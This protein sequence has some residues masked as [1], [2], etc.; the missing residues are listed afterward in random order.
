MYASSNA[1]TDSTAIYKKIKE[2]SSKRKLTTWLY[3]A[4]FVDPKPQ[5]YPVQP[6]ST[7]EKNVNP[8][9]K[10]EGRIIKKINVTVYDPFGHSVN[11]TIVRK[12]NTFEKGANRAHI[13]T[14]H[15]VI[16]NKLLFKENDELEAIEL[17]ESERLLRQ[18][19]FISDAR[20]FINEIKNTD[21]IIVNVLV[22]DKWAVTA[23]VIL[24]DI[25]VNA[26]FRNQ[27]MLGTGQQFEQFAEFRKPN[28]HIFSGIY[29]IANLD[30][31]YI[32]SA[33]SY[34]TD[35]VGTQVGLAFDRPFFSPLT[36]WAGGVSLNYTQRFYDY[37]DTLD[38]RRKCANLTMYNYDVWAGKSIKLNTTR[39]FF[40]QSTNIILGARYYSSPYI[41]RPDIADNIM[42]RNHNTSAF[43][44]NVGFAVQ[45]FYKDKFIYRFGANED[46]PE[47]LIVQLLY[48]GEKKEISPLRYYTAIEIARAKHFD[49][50]Y[51]TSTFSHNIFFNKYSANNITS[52]YKLYYFSNLLRL[53]KWYMR[54]FVNYNLTYGENKPADERITLTGS[55][56]YG[57]NAGSLRGTKKMVTNFETVAYAPY[58]V[59]GFRFAPVL[60]V[61]L[62]VIG[63]EKNKLFR[64]NL[65]QA[66]S[67]G[68]MVRNE[69]LVS[70]T[71]QMTVG[72]YPLLPD[73]KKEHVV[74]NP[75]LSFTLRVR[76][77]LVAKPAFIAY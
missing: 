23:P 38:G 42:R 35:K 36:E 49:F 11:D 44:G 61:G 13:T 56:L 10:Y 39:S 64:S 54:E 1:Q 75:V 7:E 37:S 58:N 14:R 62:G 17:S 15:W 69:N 48:G 31:T 28:E 63:D 50:G 21:S 47:G 60:M 9:L 5:E 20:V 67:L 73:G 8:Y 59:I 57:F 40:N 32:S 68:L 77:F 30:N 25:L 22:Q 46:V 18:S 71:F 24:S 19:V 65:Y 34:H 74:Y 72:F 29:T 12:I 4:I 26:R 66:Y 33:L 55:D 52:H 43:I 16:K 51:L 27:N 70:S 45:Q 2:F 76:T 53:G 3:Q 6:A 41:K